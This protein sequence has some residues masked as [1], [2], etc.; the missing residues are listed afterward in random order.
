MR[1]HA[2]ACQSGCG[3]P[4]A[5]GA[6]ERVGRAHGRAATTA[7][8]LL[9][10]KQSRQQRAET[11][12]RSG[13][14]GCDVWTRSRAGGGWLSRVADYRTMGWRGE[15]GLA[16][17]AVSTLRL[18]GASCWVGEQHDRY[19]MLWEG[20]RL[21]NRHYS[22]PTWHA[23]L[24]DKELRSSLA[25]S[26]PPTSEI[27]PRPFAGTGHAGI[28]CWDE[29]TADRVIT[30]TTHKQPLHPRPACVIP[31]GMSWVSSPQS[32]LCDLLVRCGVCMYY[33]IRPPPTPKRP[34]S[35]AKGQAERR[36]NMSAA[37]HSK[38]TPRPTCSL[39]SFIALPYLFRSVPL[40]L[41]PFLRHAS[42]ACYHPKL[43][44]LL[45]PYL[46][47]LACFAMLKRASSGVNTFMKLTLSYE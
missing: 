9:A 47:G 6:S 28:C 15:H 45:P 27:Q 46:P 42:L 24:R 8:M 14:E 34:S 23:A 5:A 19:S 37:A 13:L 20:N 32:Q 16:P 33:D 25:Q 21:H 3:R 22:A 38:I 26:P 10:R 12:Y 44:F 39:Y 40:P 7:H 30:S 43:N 18:L 11:T 41:P 35:A 1:L 17:A 2:M 31:I 4:R 36:A 29:R